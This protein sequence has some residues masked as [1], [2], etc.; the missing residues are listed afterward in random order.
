MFTYQIR[1]CSDKAH[2]TNRSFS[3]SML[4]TWCQSERVS[5]EITLNVRLSIC[6]S[7]CQPVTNFFQNL[8]IIAF[9][10]ISYVDISLVEKNP[11]KKVW[12][13]F[14]QL[15]FSQICFIRLFQKKTNRGFEPPPPE[16]FLLPLDAGNSRQ[17]KAP[18]LWKFQKFFVRSLGNS[19][20]AKNQD[21]WGNS[22]FF[23]GHPWKF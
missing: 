16:I 14:S 10:D 11:Q 4:D 17:N 1:C 20:K 9:S 8:T 2:F 22:T 12:V 5:S 13:Q 18:P 7:V 23:L 15:P 3:T 19:K 21:P 6:L